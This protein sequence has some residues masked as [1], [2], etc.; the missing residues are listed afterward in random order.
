MKLLLLLPPGIVLD[1][2]RFHGSGTILDWLP[3]TFCLSLMCSV[4][5]TWIWYLFCG[6]RLPQMKQWRVCVCNWFVY[7]FFSQFLIDL[8]FL[9]YGK[10]H[11]KIIRHV[12][13]YYVNNI[14]CIPYLFLSIKATSAKIDHLIHLFAFKSY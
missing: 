10:V 11:S 14:F 7:H 13:I 1:A 4:L 9:L 3:G 2:M 5:L 12:D 6:T 8:Q